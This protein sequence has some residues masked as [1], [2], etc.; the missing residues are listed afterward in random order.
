[1]AVHGRARI[2]DSV[3]K[4]TITT[5]WTRCYLFFNFLCHFGFYLYIRR[6]LG[7]GCHAKK[8]TGYRIAF[9]R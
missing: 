7:F 4:A 2:I 3:L 1:V 9:D 8:S 5:C 6:H